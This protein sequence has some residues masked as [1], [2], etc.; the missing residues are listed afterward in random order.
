MKNATREILV[1]IFEL[2][3]I[4][5]D[6]VDIVPD[7]SKAIDVV[8]ESLK[9]GGKIIFCGNGGSAADSQHLAAEFVGRMLINRKPY[10]AVSLTTDT[11]IITAISND[12]SFE[13]IF[14]KQVEAI[15][16]P[17]DVF[18]G[19]TTSGKSPNIL[20]A[21]EVASNIGMKII[22]LTGN[23][24][25]YLKDFI[26]SIVLSV[27]SEQTPRIQECHILIG[28]IIAEVVESSMV[29]YTKET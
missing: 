5:P 2:N 18:F 21:A 10:A 11:S 16:K 14:S 25:K 9:N 23:K 29:E 3:D 28:H 8:T 12:F 1:K 17:E 27:P 6:L 13:E 19:I 4:L 20:K 22:F 7:I 24:G 15:G 26:D